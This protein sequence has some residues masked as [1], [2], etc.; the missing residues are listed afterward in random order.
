MCPIFSGCGDNSCLNV[1]HKKPYKRYEGKTNDV[2]IAFIGYVNDRNNFATV[3][4][5]CSKITP[6]TSMQ[7]SA[8]L[9]TVRVALLRSSWRSCFMR[10]ALFIMRATNS[11][12][13][14]T[15]LFIHPH[16]Q[17]SNLYAPTS[18]SCIFTPIENW[19]HVY[20]NLFTRNSAYY[21]LLKYL[22]FLLKHTHTHTYIYSHT[23]TACESH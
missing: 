6:S 21:H 15:S 12:L 20:I 9:A 1:T 17:K 7:F 18:N 11:S 4:S 13:V 22:L 3:H 2:L 5:K 16:R 23:H 10:A 19:T 14:F 8:L